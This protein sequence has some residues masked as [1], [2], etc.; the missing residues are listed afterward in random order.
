MGT[1]RHNGSLIVSS[2]FSQ[3]EPKGISST[4]ADRVK[5]AKDFSDFIKQQMPPDPA[6]AA[7]PCFGS[8]SDEQ[9]IGQRVLTNTPKVK[10]DVEQ[11]GEMGAIFYL[12]NKLADNKAD[13]DDDALRIFD[14]A[15]AF[16]IVLFDKPPPY[17]TRAIIVEAKGGESHLGP[18]LDFNKTAY[19]TQ[20][21]TAYADTIIKV[22]K[23]SKDS[24]RRD[25]GNMLDTLVGKT[26]P[27]VAYVGVQTKYD[28][29]KAVI[30]EPVPIFFNTL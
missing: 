24:K 15:H 10:K 23:N 30:Y 16:N 13:Y 25:A 8:D 27:S 11:L 5:W 1:F 18:R 29:V 22:M 19:V 14:G 26:P 4:T 28:Q 12:Q 7:L 6:A 3:T 21:S 20:G 2:S 9:M 17:A